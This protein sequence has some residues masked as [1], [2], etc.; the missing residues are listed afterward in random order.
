MALA[1]D[2]PSAFEVREAVWLADDGPPSLVPNGAADAANPRVSDHCPELACLSGWLSQATAA[3]A[4]ARAKRLG[5]GAD[6]VLLARGS[7]DEEIYVR[8]LA[9]ACDIPFETLASTRRADCNLSDERL[10]K[11]IALGLLP[12]RTER[13]LKFVVAPRL[14]GARCLSHLRRARPELLNRFYL[15]TDDY[16]KRFVHRHAAGAIGHE[17][18]QRLH[19]KHPTLSAGPRA[20]TISLGGV[21]VLAA[22]LLAV[23]LSFAGPLSIPAGIL[24]SSIFWCWIAFRACC[25]CLRPETERP[26]WQS[27]ESLPTYTVIVALYHEVAAVDGLIQ[28]LRQIDYP[29]EKLDIKFVVEPGDPDTFQALEAHRRSLPFEIVV[30]PASGPRTKPKALNTALLF[31]RGAY[32]VIFDA[33][34]RPDSLQLRCAL[35]EFGMRGPDVACVQAA[36]TIDNTDDSWLAALFTAEYAAQFDVV[37][38]ALSRLGL[39]LPLGGSSNHFRTSVLRDVGGWDP[40]NVTED[41]DL[42]LRL[43]RFGYR[44]VTISSSTYEE[45]PAEL[46]SWLK[47]RTRWFKGWMQ[48]WL[49]HLR[50]PVALCRDLGLARFLAAQLTIGASV[51]SALLHPLAF[52]GVLMLVAFGHAAPSV[53]LLFVATAVAGYV[54]SA[55]VAMVGLR[56][57]GLGRYGRFLVLMPIHWMLLSI[58]AWRAFVQLIHDP[59]RWEKTAHGRARHSRRPAAVAADSGSPAER[60][61]S[62]QKLKE[63]GSRSSRRW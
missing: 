58:A 2:R 5:I 29:V 48:T 53:A 25:A 14:L 45:A 41:A 32:T 9:D 59:Y 13:G 50:H 10:I 22:I 1:F 4:R 36:L 20:T 39:P 12:L 33:E 15:T 51:G 37:L 57:R 49:V 16:L 55:V 42:G 47:Q 7:V 6:R 21:A 46:R 8:A 54:G 52:V 60:Q 34:D 38:P 31:A 11:A 44:S 62:S 19:T 40:Y 43:A 23:G 35:A 26:R 56:R 17:A 61:G 28:A 30:A 18:A 63:R 27:D 3:H 24:V